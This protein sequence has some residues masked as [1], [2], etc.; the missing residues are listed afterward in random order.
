MMSEKISDEQFADLE[1]K[2]GEIVEVNTVL[3]PCIF[4]RPARAD[5]Q[6]YLSYL[7]DEKKR[8]SAQEILVRSCVVS[9]NKETFGQ[10][11]DVAPGIAVT[12]SG[13]CLELAGQSGEPEVARR[14]RKD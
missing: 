6:R 4:K 5:Y 14:S 10:M 7:F 1:A 8:A 3:G 11:L 2:Y 9:P 13:P 12:C